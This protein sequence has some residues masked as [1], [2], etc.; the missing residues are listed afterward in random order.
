MAVV[1]KI[2]LRTLFEGLYGIKYKS[3][4]DHIQGCIMPDSEYWDSLNS[5]QDS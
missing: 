3:E 1:I 5:S 4:S 2:I